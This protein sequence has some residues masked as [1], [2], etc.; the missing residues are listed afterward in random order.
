MWCER[1]LTHFHVF[2]PFPFS[3]KSNG[4]RCDVWR[5]VPASRAQKP[6]V[7]EATYS[8]FFFFNASINDLI[9]TQNSFVFGLQQLQFFNS[10]SFGYK[11]L[12]NPQFGLD[13]YLSSCGIFVSS[14]ESRKSW[15]LNI[16]SIPCDYALLH[17]HLFLS[18]PSHSWGRFQAVASIFL[19]D[20]Y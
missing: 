7:R 4:E 12:Q 18:L 5:K 1:G 14:R 20:S 11:S 10:W 8:F 2:R 15:S 17:H 19:P 9:W 16:L 3:V 13:A 6:S